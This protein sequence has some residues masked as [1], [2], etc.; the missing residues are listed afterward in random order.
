ME[1]QIIELEFRKDKDNKTIL[2]NSENINKIVK[3]ILP[4]I[5]NN[6]GWG[7]KDLVRDNFLKNPQK[8]QDDIDATLWNNVHIL[9]L[10]GEPAALL[11]YSK[12]YFSDQTIQ[13]HKTLTDLFQARNFDEPSSLLGKKFDPQLAEEVQEFIRKKPIYTNLGLV[14]RPNL[15]GKKTGISEKM[16]AIVNDGIAFGWTSNPII[17]RQ[18]R[19]AF[20]KMVFFPAYGE[21][22]NNVQEWSVCLY[23]YADWITHE[24]DQIADLEFGTMR[25]PYFVNDRGEEYIKL[26]KTISEASKI[27][28]LDEK[29]LRYVLSQKSCAAAIVSWN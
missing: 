13:R 14:L 28:H 22:P 11:E 24:K 8:Y 7:T 21:F 12:H 17:V 3:W 23:V 26:A 10:G 6:E 29:R 9:T 25:S 5:E 4:I 27:T 15:Q 2:T 16:Y 20:K 18:W 1:T 19:K